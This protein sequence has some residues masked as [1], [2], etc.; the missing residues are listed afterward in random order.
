[1]TVG[2]TSTGSGLTSTTSKATAPQAQSTTPSQAFLDATKRHQDNLTRLDNLIKNGKKE[3]RTEWGVKWPN[4]CEWLSA[5]KTSLHALTETHDSAA[6]ATALGKGGDKVMFGI[7]VAVPTASDYNETVQTDKR[8]VTT[9]GPKWLGFRRAGSPSKVAIIEPT[10]RTDDEV[11]NTVVHEVQHD[12][13]HAQADA[14]GGYSSEFRAYWICG[15]FKS[16]SAAAKSA[17]DT[18]TTSA[19]SGGTVLSGFDNARQQAIFK[20]L[21]ES[22]SY[23]YVKASWDADSQGFKAKVLAMKTPRGTNLINSPTLDDIYLELNKP[24]PDV[25]KIEKLAE[26]LTKDDKNEIKAGGM[27]EEWQS[28]IQDKLKGDDLTRVTK[29]VGL[30]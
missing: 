6:R 12:A 13:D 7:D 3:G 5:G 28:L 4:S 23:A 14:W 22:K 10:K 9:V 20:H 16:Y 11:R 27:K 19:D 1:M 18:L 29:A 30:G 15:S 21:Y 8:N 25:A 24:S 17:D 2:T 26:K